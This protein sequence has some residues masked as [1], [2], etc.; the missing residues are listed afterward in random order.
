MKCVLAPKAHIALCVHGGTDWTQWVTSTGEGHTRG[1]CWGADSVGYKH[2]GGAY[3]RD[4]LG[5]LVGVRGQFGVDFGNDQDTL[6]ICTKLSK[7]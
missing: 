3:E 4:V 5:C 1:M 2:G 7:N 6:L